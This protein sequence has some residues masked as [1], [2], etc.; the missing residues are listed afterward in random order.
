LWLDIKI[1]GM[2][3]WKILRR[4]GINHPGHATMEEFKG[5]VHEE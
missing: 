4:E 2:T 5:T 3:I 1:I